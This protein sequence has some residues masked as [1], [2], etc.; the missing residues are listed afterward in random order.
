[1]PATTILFLR[2]GETDWNVAGR[3]QG[4]RDIPLNDRGRRQAFENGRRMAQLIPGVARFEFVCS[5]LERARNTM[6][7]AREAMGL[8]P[9]DYVLDERLREIT[10]GAWE[11]FT[12]DELRRRDPEAVEARERDKWNFEPPEGESYAELSQRVGAWLAS[13]SGPVM[14]VSHGGVARVLYRYLERADPA[15]AANIDIPQDRFLYWEGE[16]AR[17]V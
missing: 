7:I 1:M 9:S 17:W 15:F 16:A 3:L 4:Q 11:G 2:H 12:L 13:L 14:A 6:E 5:P 8:V 10:F